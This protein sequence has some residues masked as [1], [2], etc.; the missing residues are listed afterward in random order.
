MGQRCGQRFN[1][2]QRNCNYCFNLSVLQKTRALKNLLILALS[3]VSLGGYSQLDSILFDGAYRTYKLHVPASYDGSL[4]TPLV[5]GMHGGFGNGEQ[6]EQQSLLSEKADEAGFI[7]VYPNGTG[8]NLA[9]NLRF[10]NAGICCGYASENDVDDVGFISDLIDSLSAEYNIDQFRVFATGMSNGAQM[11]Y[12]L[13]CEIPE[14]IGAIAPV[15]GSLQFMDCTPVEPV[16]VIHFHSKLDSNVPYLGGV[17]DGPSQHYNPPLDSVLTAW[18][19]HDGC[20]DYQTYE[21]ANEYTY[22]QWYDCEC[23]YTVDYYLTED[24]G[25]SWPGGNGTVIGD[26]PSE[27]INAND[28]MWEFFLINDNNCNA[29][30]IEEIESSPGSIK[31][32]PNPGGEVLQIATS[33]I[34]KVQV[35]TVHSLRGQLLSEHRLE[36]R[37]VIDKWATQVMLNSSDWPSGMYTVRAVTRSETLQTSLMVR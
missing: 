27:V 30:S 20:V 5:V 24:G 14:K 6:F 21:V 9:P 3:L 33:T 29:T 8:Y 32:Y 31:I 12:R 37:K 2:H 11:S 4:S 13:A 18:N 1:S 15:A 22:E 28:L 25:H 34:D 26:D 17:G 7:A 16:P 35:I 23:L 36:P 10:W 19:D